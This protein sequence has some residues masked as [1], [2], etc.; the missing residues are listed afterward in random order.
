MF[1]ENLVAGEVSLVVGHIGGAVVD[2]V[3]DLL[4]QGQPGVP[5]LLPGVGRTTGLHHR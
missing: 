1:S 4:Q 5:L 3:G 2:L